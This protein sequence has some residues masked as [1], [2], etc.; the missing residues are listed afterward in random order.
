MKII[1]RADG[2]WAGIP[3]L[4]AVTNADTN[5]LSSQSGNSG[6]NGNSI[7]NKLIDNASGIISSIGGS[8][9]SA[10][11]AK[12]GNYPQ[13]ASIDETPKV[14]AIAAVAAIVLIV[15]VLIIFKK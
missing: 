2:E 12:T 11:A 10:I 4:P 9:T 5:S 6:R 14:L 15:I 8:V 1:R 3:Y 13:A 7:W